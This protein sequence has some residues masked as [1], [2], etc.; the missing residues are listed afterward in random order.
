MRCRWIDGIWYSISI[1][2]GS[3]D[4]LEGYLLPRLQGLAFALQQNVNS[5]PGVFLL[6]V[7]IVA[8]AVGGAAVGAGHDDRW[9]GFLLVYGWIVAVGPV[10]S[11]R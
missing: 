5:D 10:N 11:T 3:L 2:A 7:A 6:L 1:D 9:H 4:E 8:T